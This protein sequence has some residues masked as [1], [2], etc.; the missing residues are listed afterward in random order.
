MA[1]GRNF[2]LSGSMS[3]D[4]NVI[5]ENVSKSPF[6]IIVWA[7]DTVANRSNDRSVSKLDFLFTKQKQILLI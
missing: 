5:L 7:C 3:N 2:N 1:S 6:S 4:C